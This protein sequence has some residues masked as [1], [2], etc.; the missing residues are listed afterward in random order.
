MNRILIILSLCAALSA[1][2]A[3]SL[4]CQ[5]TTS[6][7]YWASA[8]KSQKIKF[9]GQANVTKIVLKVST[10]GTE[11]PL[12]VSIHTDKDGTGTLLGQ[13]RSVTTNLADV[14]PEWVEF[15]CG[16]G[17]IPVTNDF[18]ISLN[19]GLRWL[20]SST[21]NYE[22]TSYYLTYG[23]GEQ[24]GKD[25]A[26]MVYTN[27][28]APRSST[29]TLTA[30]DAVTVQA[31]IDD[32]MAG[33]V[34]VLPAG[35]TNW[36]VTVNWWDKPLTI[37]GAGISQTVITNYQTNA[38]SSGEYPAL[39]IHATTNGLCTLDGMSFST[40]DT[41]CMIELIPVVGHKYPA[42][43]ITRCG[44]ERGHYGGIVINGLVASV[45]DHCGFTNIAGAFFV[46]ADQYLDSWTDDLTLGTTNTAV[47]EDCTFF[48]NT[49]I[50]SGRTLILLCDTGH[51]SRVALRNSTLISTHADLKFSPIFM[52]HGNQDTVRGSRQQELYGWTCTTA[53]MDDKLTDLRGGTSLIFSNTFV[54]S[55]MRTNFTAREEDG[56]F[57]EWSTYTLVPPGYDPNVI[58]AWNN[59]SKGN[60]VTALELYYETTDPPFFIENTDVFWSAKPGYTPLVYP[61]P[62]VTLQDGV[63]SEPEPEPTPTR[64]I[65]TFRATNLIIR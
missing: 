21:E 65:G 64:N 1:S 59:V 44:F 4:H 19:Y 18:W 46:Y 28:Y 9:I 58:Y 10:G 51:G 23:G 43:R 8:P 33:E 56:N 61:H 6:D 7:D 63:G 12:Q 42:A 40:L 49:D 35:R 26:F 36:P 60:P 31:G 5:Q 54:G 39:S 34:L 50:I 14:S 53:G 24:T 32:M 20:S 38:T 37:Y 22:G 17:G 48:Y 15:V 30:L 3:E 55:G 41:N 52:F 62:L 2:A 29:N 45:V 11:V 25:Y 57:P 16:R 13:S 27:T 47:F